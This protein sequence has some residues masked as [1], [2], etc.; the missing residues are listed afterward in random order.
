MTNNEYVGLI[1]WDNNG[2]EV[3]DSTFNNNGWGM[4]FFYSSNINVNNCIVS[5]NH[6]AAYFSGIDNISFTENIFSFNGLPADVYAGGL[7]STNSNCTIANNVFEGNYDA[8]MWSMWNENVT[9]TLT[10]HDNVF[11][12]NKY[13]F[14]FY[15]ELPN[16]YTG[17]NLYFYNNLV[18]DTAYVD[19]ACLNATF[20]GTNLPF[21]NLIFKLNA[22]LQSGA[23]IYTNS[24]MT[25]RQLLG[26]SQRLGFQPDW[27]RCQP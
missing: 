7:E 15:N 26:A 20:S 12:N 4:E 24:P 21:N 11:Q 9:A 2:Y 27:S 18:N 23:R 25:R 3:I 16:N 22:T 17:Q 19:P 1:G 14:F 5:E 10:V 8:L 13:T 6:Q